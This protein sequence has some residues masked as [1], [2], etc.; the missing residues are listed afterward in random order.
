M[1]AMTVRPEKSSKFSE[2]IEV[3][4]E[5]VLDAARYLDEAVTSGDRPQVSVKADKTLVMNLDLESQRRIL[6]R[7]GGSRPIVAEEDPTSHTLIHSE[8]SYFVVDPLDG[9]TSCKRFLGQRGGHVGYGPLVGYVH[10]HTLSLAAF[11]SV[12]HRKLFT[13]VLGEGTYETLLPPDW[14]GRGETRKLV[15]EPCPSLDTAGMLFFIS[16]QGEARVVDYLRRANAI[17]NVYRFGGFANDSARLAQG[18]EQIQFQLYAKPWDFTAVLLAAE[19]GCEVI[20]DPLGRRTPLAKWRI[21]ANNP[22]VAIAP[23]IRDEFFG[24]LNGLK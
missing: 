17:E 1:A 20:C 22:I 10:E 19:A 4:E 3:V 9:T 16:P 24:A 21:E 18:F 2:V 14:K 5:A 13:A 12:P 15:V 11:Y 23:G 6:A 7:L 8:S